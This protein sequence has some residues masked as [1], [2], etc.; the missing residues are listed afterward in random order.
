MSQ[1]VRLM[2][3]ALTICLTY[4]SRRTLTMYFTYI[5]LKMHI[6]MRFR[7]SPKLIQLQELLEEGNITTWF[8]CWLSVS[9]AWSRRGQ[10]IHS[11]N[12]RIWWASRIYP[13]FWIWVR[14]RERPARGRYSLCS[15]LCKYCHS[16]NYDSSKEN[17]PDW[18]DIPVLWLSCCEYTGLSCSLR[19]CVFR[20]KPEYIEGTR[21]HNGNGNWCTL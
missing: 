5:N 9:T 17:V 15:V 16:Q 6:F 7:Y 3:D 18:M 2:H 13:W 20:R 10:S 1:K 19:V 14:H 12:C 21:S 4:A 8:R 11:Q